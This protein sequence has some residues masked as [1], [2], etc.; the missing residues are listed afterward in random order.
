MQINRLFIWPNHGLK[1]CRCSLLCIGHALYVITWC[2]YHIICK[3]RDIALFKTLEY[4]TVTKWKRDNT[5]FFPFFIMY[6]P[7]WKEALVERLRV[8]K[9][10]SKCCGPMITESKRCIIFFQFPWFS[11]LCKWFCLCDNPLWTLNQI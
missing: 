10:W 5:G 4:R 2:E 8:V 1:W 3:I 9:P 7:S 11:P 6:Y